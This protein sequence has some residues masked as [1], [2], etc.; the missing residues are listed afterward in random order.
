MKTRYLFLYL[1]ILCGAF[2]FGLPSGS[3]AADPSENSKA[4]PLK[5]IVY[6]IT[7]AGIGDVL[8]T[9]KFWD[10]DKGLRIVPNLKNLT[11]GTHGFHLH[12]FPDCS[13]ME[14]DGKMVPGLAA[15]G[16]FDPDHTGEHMGPEGDGHKGDLPFLTVEADG[17]AHKSLLVPHLTLADL[18]GH[19]F[20]IHE[21]GD[22]YSD[23]PKPLG[24]GGI[25]IACAIV[26]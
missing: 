2:V 12:E 8:G 14:K 1:S 3:L 21:G 13:P 25:R 7:D 26:P 10:T 6:T 11:P 5:V 24:G 22:N 16:H 19:A 18:H 23:D 20:I 17:T 9:L 4:A 15:G